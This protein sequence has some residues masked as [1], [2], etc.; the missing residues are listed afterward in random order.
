[1]ESRLE[2]PTV[3]VTAA[4]GAAL[5][6][7]IDVLRSG[8]YRVV[9]VDANPDAAGL[10]LADAG[11]CIPLATQDSFLPTIRDICSRE[12]AA[13]I[14]PLVDEE[15]I[16]ISSLAADGSLISLAPGSRFC[17]LCLDKFS[18]AAA[19][20]EADLPVPE[21]RLLAEGWSGLNFPLVAKPRS[22]RGSR[23]LFIAQNEK[24]LQ[25]FVADTQPDPNAYLLQ[26]RIEGDEYTVSVVCWRDGVVR[27]VVPKKIIKKEGIT[28]LAVTER[29]EAIDRLC[30]QIQS[31]LAADGPFN[32][33]LRIDPATGV[34]YTFEINPRF[35]TTTSLTHAA[36]AHEIVALLDLALGRA[37]DHA[38]AWA[39]GVTLIRHSLD[40]FQPF[41]SFAARRKSLNSGA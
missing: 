25:D 4:G 16:P 18:L 7:I 14:I 3:L 19:F 15:L 1:M 38:W 32:V 2:S 34:P 11:Y 35:S 31:R 36:G 29:S 24:D 23:G 8:G 41:S 40:T 9:A 13:A 30:R 20:R 27:A 21:T 5:P 17:A 28:K 39:E 22:G 37:N 6:F 33:Q 10:Y 12:K 26:Q